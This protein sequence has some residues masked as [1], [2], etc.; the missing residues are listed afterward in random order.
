M[1][2]KTIIILTTTIAIA[3]LSYYFYEKIRVQQINERVDSLED[4]LKR[5][6]EAKDNS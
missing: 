4:A 5:L 1:T 3:S 6:Q 2:Q